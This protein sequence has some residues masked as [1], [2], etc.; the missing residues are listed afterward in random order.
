MPVKRKKMSNERIEE[1]FIFFEGI[2]DKPSYNN[3]A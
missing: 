3:I 2:Q 1:I